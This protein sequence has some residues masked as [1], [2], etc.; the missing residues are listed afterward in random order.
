M[1]IRFAAARPSMTAFLG[2]TLWS[3]DLPCIGNDNAPAQNPP[4]AQAAPDTPPS[5]TPDEL[6]RE[7]LLHFAVHGLG[8][9]HEAKHEAARCF[10]LGREAEY[11]HWLAICR[12]FDRRMASALS[13]KLEGKPGNAQR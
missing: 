3:P 8:A 7:A 4:P 13:R 12:H 6:L 5:Y 11:R 2:R 10:A 1:T 9:A